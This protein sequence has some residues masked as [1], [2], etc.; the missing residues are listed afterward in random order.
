MNIRNIIHCQFPLSLQL[1]FDLW[2]PL[3]I[4]LA[5]CA[6]VERYTTECMIFDPKLDRK[7]LVGPKACDSLS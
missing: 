4:F 3:Q 5:M 7:G 1:L 6:F 2:D